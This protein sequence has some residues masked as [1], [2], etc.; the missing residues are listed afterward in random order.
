MVLVPTLFFKMKQTEIDFFRYRSKKILVSNLVKLFI[1]IVVA[2]F[3]LVISYNYWGSLLAIFLLI[4]VLFCGCY[5]FIFIF[6]LYRNWT[7][8]KILSELCEYADSLD[9]YSIEKR[10]D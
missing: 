2:C 3:F 4:P 5:I 7:D 6:R 10:E 8:Y 1:F 9:V